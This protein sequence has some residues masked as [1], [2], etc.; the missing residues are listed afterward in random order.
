MFTIGN[1][2]KDVHRCF[3]GGLVNENLPSIA[4]DAGSIPGQ[5]TKIQHAVGQ[6]NSRAATREARTQQRTP[7]IAKNRG[8]KE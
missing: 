3:P 2:Y 6:L 5:G 1:M 7:S 8:G 4:G